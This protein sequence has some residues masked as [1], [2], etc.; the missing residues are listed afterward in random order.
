MSEAEGLGFTG[1]SSKALNMQV[2]LVI[3]F[4]ISSDMGA[5][6]AKPPGLKIQL[7]QTW[8]LKFN[9]PEPTRP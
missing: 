5:L 9:P 3:K 6:I 2:F 4:M 8:V 7:T 1:G